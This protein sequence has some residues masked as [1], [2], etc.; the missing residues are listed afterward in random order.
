MIEH[1]RVQGKLVDIDGFQAVDAVTAA[2]V[3]AL[4][5]RRA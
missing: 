4:E 3:K 5:S 1:Y 2:L